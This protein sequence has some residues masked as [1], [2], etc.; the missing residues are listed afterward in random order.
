MQLVYFAWVRERIGKSEETLHL[1]ESV[2]T[3]RELLS[4]LSGINEIYAHALAE[5]EKLRVAVNQTHVQ[6][7]HPVIDTDEVAIF[8]PVTGG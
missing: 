8:P 4:Y 5:P 3:V 1:P 2:T 6:L 7:D